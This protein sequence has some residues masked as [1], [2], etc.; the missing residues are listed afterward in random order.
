MFIARENEPSY[1]DLCQLPEFPVLRDQNV[2]NSYSVLGIDKKGSNPF[3][4]PHLQIRSKRQF[5][6]H[7]RRSVARH[8]TIPGERCQVNISL[9][10]E[11]SAPSLRLNLHVLK[12]SFI[13]PFSIK[14]PKPDFLLENHCWASTVPRPIITANIQKVLPDIQGVN[15]AWV[16]WFYWTYLIMVRISSGYSSIRRDATASLN[17][18]KRIDVPT[19][20]NSSE[21]GIR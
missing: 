4:F 10:P 13:Q 16:S 6:I 11:V 9:H 19:T 14:Y 7:S 2:P 18:C 8:R 12:F 17:H 15:W 1:G 21:L 5:R 20:N 3:A